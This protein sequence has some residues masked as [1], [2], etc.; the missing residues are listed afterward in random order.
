L[1]LLDY[2]SPVAGIIWVMPEGGPAATLSAS[3]ARERAESGAA[4]AMISTRASAR[5]LCLVLRGNAEALEKSAVLAEEDARRRAEAGRSREAAA[6][7]RVAER[8][9]QAAEQ[10]RLRAR[11]AADWAY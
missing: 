9:R 2:V 7:R 4:R 8:A 3:K 11:E 10:A 1:P 5:R 6:E